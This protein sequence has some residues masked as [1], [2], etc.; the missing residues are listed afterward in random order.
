MRAGGRGAGG[1]GGGRLR[2]ALTVRSSQV[3]VQ[4]E[5]CD[6][7]HLHSPHGSD[8]GAGTPMLCPLPFQH[9][10]SL[11]RRLKHDRRKGRK[12]A[13]RARRHRRLGE[14]GWGSGARRAGAGWARAGRPWAGRAGTWWVGAGGWRRRREEGVDVQGGIGP[15]RHGQH[16]VLK[17]AGRGTVG[18]QAGSSLLV[19]GR[20]T[21]CQTHVMHVALPSGRLPGLE[22]RLCPCLSPAGQAEQLPSMASSPSQGY[23]LSHQGTGTEG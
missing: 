19:G 20:H 8:T 6:A 21:R 1:R 9:T 10:S 7:Q 3:C 12:R 18:R 2:G 17:G 11:D 22:N 5:D 23:R 13:P 16:R 4:P 15:V 14:R